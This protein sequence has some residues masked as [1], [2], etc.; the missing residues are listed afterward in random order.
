MSANLTKELGMAPGGE[1]RR[2]LE[3]VHR[4]EDCILQLG[5]R[6]INVTLQR[7]IHGLSIWQ[8]IKIIWKIA[9]SN[10]NITKEDVERCKQKDLLDELMQELGGEYPAFQDVFV[11]ERDM[12]LCHSLQVAA[13]PRISKTGQE[14]RP[15]TVVGVV[16]IG[17]CT[18]ITNLWGKVDSARIP[19]ISKIP[20]ASL[21]SRVVK[22][23]V[24]YGVLSLIG[25]GV[26]R[27]VRPRL[28]FKL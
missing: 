9:T 24:K 8:T 23:S 17:H 26:F 11:K 14:P 20:P 3:E 19:E 5:D 13:M 25:Y 10:D 16:G 27:L 2:A 1:F 21:T 4:L 18:G 22:F 6:P 7:A 28:P 15:V 12:Y